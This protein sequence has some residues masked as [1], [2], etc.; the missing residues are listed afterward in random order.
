MISPNLVAIA[1]TAEGAAR[2]AEAAGP[3]VDSMGGPLGVLGRAMG[4]SQEQIE[5]GIPGWAWAATGLLGGIVVGYL[6]HD[7]IEA[8]RER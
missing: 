8:F 3:L 1:G 5:A 4:L 7:K 6:L 2:T